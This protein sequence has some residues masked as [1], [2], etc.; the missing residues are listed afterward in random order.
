MIKQVTIKNNKGFLETRKYDEN[1]NEIEYIN[2]IG[3]GYKSIYDSNNNKLVRYIYTSD[4][5]VNEYKYDDDG[6]IIRSCLGDMVTDYTYDNAGNLVMIKT[7]SNISKYYYNSKGDI[8]IELNIVN[9][10]ITMIRTCKYDYENLTLESFY[11]NND[12]SNTQIIKYKTK[13]GL[14]EIY[15]EDTNN[16]KYWKEYDERGLLIKL[17]SISGK[18]IVYKYNDSGKL[19]SEIYNNGYEKHYTYNTLGGVIREEDSNGNIILIEYNQ[20]GDI[21]KK[22]NLSTGDIEEYEYIYY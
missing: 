8:L 18:E 4:N 10:E 14:D 16:E 3:T 19:V 5:S 13:I 17:K 21:R 22:E 2:S 6:N 12:G 7:G 20:T 1:G 15:Y 9:D 11:K